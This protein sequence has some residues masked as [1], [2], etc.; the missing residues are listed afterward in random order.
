MSNSYKIDVTDKI[1]IVTGGYGH[2]GGAIVESL[3]LHGAIVIVAGRDKKKFENKFS[4][5]KKLD[6]YEFDISDEQSIIS[7]F[8]NIFFKYGKIDVLIN[9]AYFMNYVTESLDDYSKW[10]NGIDGVLNSVYLASKEVIPYF[11]K[12]KHGN[13]IN[14]ASMYGIVAPDFDIYKNANEYLSPDNYG[15]SK[16]GVIQLTKYFAS[17]YG[18]KNIRVNSVSP[19][20]FPSNEVQKNNKFINELESKTILKRIGKPEDLAGIFTFLSS[21]ASNYITGQNFIVDGGWTAR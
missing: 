20:P 17:F 13:I 5:N 10:K 7:C 4:I 9:N 16:A 15:V 19:G 18:H 12:Q 11:E 8:S 14:V 6:F 21:E 1:I 2:L 3:L